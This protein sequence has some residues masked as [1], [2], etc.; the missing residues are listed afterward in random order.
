[1]IGLFVLIKT[2]IVLNLFDKL[3]MVALFVKDLGLGMLT[4]FLTYKA[5]VFW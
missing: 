5:S 1:M 3:V 4:F 2:L